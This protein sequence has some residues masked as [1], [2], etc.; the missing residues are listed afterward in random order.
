MYR[1]RLA[2]LA[3]TATITI[4]INGGHDSRLDF[5]VLTYTGLLNI[6][7]LRLGT[8]EDR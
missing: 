4:Q 6:G 3:Y 8:R 5:C 7:L 2:Y 1:L